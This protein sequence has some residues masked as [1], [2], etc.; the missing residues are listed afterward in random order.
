MSLNFTLND[1]LQVQKY[2]FTTDLL[3]LPSNY[4]NIIT[5][6]STFSDQVF[7]H[8]LPSSQKTAQNLEHNRS[9]RRILEFSVSKSIYII[10]SL[11]TVSSKDL[12][13]RFCLKR[14]QVHVLALS[15]L[16]TN[17]HYSPHKHS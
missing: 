12:L 3:A 11:L 5:S 8:I 6:I 7:I 15:Q 16:I 17:S 10:P 1:L 9:L 13:S 2:Q 4:V 14:A